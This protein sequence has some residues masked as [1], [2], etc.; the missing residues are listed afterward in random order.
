MFCSNATTSCDVEIILLA[1][2]NVSQNYAPVKFNFTQDK[3]SEMR[4]RCRQAEKCSAKGR[5]N[6]DPGKGSFSLQI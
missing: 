1:P 6:I 5:A 4:T 3:V 2:R